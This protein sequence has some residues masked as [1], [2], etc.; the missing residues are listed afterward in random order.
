[1]TLA[2]LALESAL[3]TEGVVST[4]AGPVGTRVT[5]GGGGRLRGVVAAARADGRYG[6][7]LHL[8]TRVVPLHPLAA[9]VRAGVGQAARVAGLAES[10]GPI[11]IT[12]DDVAETEGAVV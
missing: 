3:A 10:L 1:M 4:D 7:E 11:D 9:R 8:V 2:R 6:I 5:R 12:I